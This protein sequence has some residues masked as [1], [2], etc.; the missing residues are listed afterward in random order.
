[1][2]K[3]LVTVV[4]P[5]RIYDLF[6]SAGSHYASTWPEHHHRDPI[7]QGRPNLDQR[8]V[9]DFY[10]K[11]RFAIVIE[12]ALQYPYTFITEKTYRPLAN[13][14]PFVVLGPAHTVSFL[15]S[16]GFKTFSSIIDESYDDIENAESRFDAV[17]EIVLFLA[18]RP[19]ESIVHDIRSVEPTLI[20]N[21]KN[22]QQLLSNQLHSLQGQISN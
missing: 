7:I 1:M 13:A 14:R 16:L 5:T 8:F 17:C 10:Q 19:I 3:S 9:T 6:I 12:T 21:Q 20:H 2:P 15:K 22:L 4:P 18:H 11:I